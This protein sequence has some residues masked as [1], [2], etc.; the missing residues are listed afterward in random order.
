M[1][2]PRFESIGVHLPTASLSTAEML[3]EIG[4][5]LT[6]DLARVTGV[7]ERR[8]Y[9]R[10][11]NDYED[12]FALAKKAA[13]ICLANS[14]YSARDLDIVISTS[15]TRTRDRTKFCFEPPFSLMLRNELGAPEA[16]YFDISNACAG[17][18]TGVMVLDR[19]I[20]AGVVE[21]GLVV[22]GE[23][24]TPIAETA[25]RE[26]VGDLDPQFAALTVGD[27][28][29]AVILD[30]DGGPGDLIDYVETMTCAEYAELC[31]GMPSDKS[32]GIAMYTDSVSMHNANRYLQGI[33]WA[34][35]YLAAQ[36]K[37]F[38]SE[39]FDFVIH[40]QFSSTAIAQI[41]EISERE[42]GLPMPRS[43]L[44]LERFGNTSSTSHFVVLHEY[45][46][47]G[48]IEKGAK[49]LLVPTASGMVFGQ[50]SA[51]VSLTVA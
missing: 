42:L 47:R 20:R 4:D 46:R 8:V 7:R 29:A 48:V 12:S 17:M 22:S 26:I 21:N 25:V 50:L 39:G 16:A 13:N 9:S 3:A 32:Q 2:T 33:Q 10:T 14:R 35:D 51:S 1:P 11:E 23:Q 43:L 49:V 5:R 40:H 19:M 6:V 41:Q 38:D 31:I 34:I 18:I 15:I 37:S 44:T 36:G 24:I 30:A 45:L 27:A 28:G